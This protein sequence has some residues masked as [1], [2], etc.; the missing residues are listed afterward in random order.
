MR[1]I[2]LILLLITNLFS[3]KKEQ[4]EYI[5]EDIEPQKQIV[6]FG[7]KYDDYNVHYDTIQAQDTFERILKKQNLNYEEIEL[8][9][10][11]SLGAIDSMNP[12]FLLVES[13][14]VICQSTLAIASGN[15]GKPAP[16]PISMISL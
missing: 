6:D 11:K 2:V 13:T 14:K 16:V 10:T 8:K 15:P 12:I 5:I 4:E 9:I 3:C 1:K 7:F